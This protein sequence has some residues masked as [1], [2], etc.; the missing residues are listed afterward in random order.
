SLLISRASNRVASAIATRYGALGQTHPELIRATVLGYLPPI[1]VET[2]GDRVWS[3]L[4]AGYRA[5]L[6]C[7]SIAAGLVYGEGLD[8]YREVPDEHPPELALSYVVRADRNREPVR[9]VERSRLAS[10]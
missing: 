5:Q 10:A 6:V 2:A 9:E 3:H 4:P 7:T 8:Y 1:L